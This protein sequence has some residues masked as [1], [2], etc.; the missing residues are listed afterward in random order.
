[1]EFDYDDELQYLRLETESLSELL[2]YYK[3]TI[4]DIYIRVKDI[5]NMDSLDIKTEVMLL[6]N[7]IKEIDF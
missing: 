5:T 6:R 7:F 3:D 2:Q 1:M 4:F